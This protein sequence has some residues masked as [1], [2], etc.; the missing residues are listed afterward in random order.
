MLNEK[1]KLSSYI[2][3]TTDLT[4]NLLCFDTEVFEMVLM[5]IRLSWPCHYVPFPSYFFFFFNNPCCD[6][7][8]GMITFM[9][10]IIWHNR[11][12]HWCLFSVSHMVSSLG[13]N[14]HFQLRHFLYIRPLLKICFTISRRASVIL[15]RSVIKDIYVMTDDN[16]QWHELQLPKH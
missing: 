12:I 11:M 5:L 4:C 14:A 15:T 9:C 7:M 6:G 16:W 13:W 8:L 2:T 3:D 10:N 1:L